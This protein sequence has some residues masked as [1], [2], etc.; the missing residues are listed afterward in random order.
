MKI[1]YNIPVE[2]HCMR[3]IA[4]IFS[5]SSISC[6][7]L[8][9]QAFALEEIPTVIVDQPKTATK[10]TTISTEEIQN[11]N[12]QN[13]P[14][15][16]EA[17]L[18]TQVTDLYSDGNHANVSIRGFG[19][20][21]AYNSLILLDGVPLSNADIGLPF[22]NFISPSQIDHIEIIPESNGVFYGDQAVGGIIN[23]ITKKP[24]TKNENITA[25]LGSYNS[26]N[27]N[28][29]ISNKLK[30]GLGYNINASHYDTN[31]YRDHNYSQLNN[32]NAILN[33]STESSESFI[34]YWKVNNHMLLPGGLTYAEVLENRQQSADNISFNNQ[35]TDILQ[36]DTKKNL[37]ENYAFHLSGLYENMSGIGAYE[38][39]DDSPYPF[40]EKR[41]NYNFLPSISGSNNFYNHTIIPNIGIS[42]SS[43]EY[44]FNDDSAKQ[45]EKSIYSEIKTF[46]TNKWSFT[47][48][49]RAASADYNLNNDTVN[50]TKPTNNATATNLETAYSL[51][52]DLRIF[53]RRADNYRFPKV[54]E[55]AWALN[56]D[57]LKTQTGT[58]YEGGID[59]HKKKFAALLEI[60]RLNLKNEIMSISENIFDNSFP[61]NENVDPTQRNGILVHSVFSPINKLQLSTNLSLLDAK[62]TEGIYKN[63]KIPFVADKTLHLSATYLLPKNLELFIEGIYVSERYLANDFANSEKPLGGFTT[64]NLGLNYKKTKYT[65]SLRVNN[66]TNKEFYS[67]AA[68]SFAN[69]SVTTAYYPAAGINALLNLRYEF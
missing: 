66:L 49:G 53:V 62:F 60:Y 14:Q 29:S 26:H 47:V 31:S 64:Y 33:Y 43:G 37:S 46:L 6:F 55:E 20:D 4:F 2:T 40:N 10:L 17:N 16:L 63:K 12:P 44:D 11:S 51:Q 9:T 69:N 58:S 13:L 42:L 25:G 35:D 54:D 38:N 8:Q 68:T 48:G 39:Q 21:A 32:I 1:Y 67:Y 27:I 30:N 15:I 65:L 7:I 23:I 19:D 59:F 50:N 56:N 22:I 61:C 57:P 5:V 52:K 3:L 28:G 34:R 36:I 18:G 45:I 24:I 41:K